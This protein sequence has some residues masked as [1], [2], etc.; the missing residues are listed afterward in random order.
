MMQHWKKYGRN[1]FARY[2]YE[3][4]DSA[5]AEKMMA[6]LA[7]KYASKEF[8]GTELK[9]KTSDAT[10]KVKL[11]DDF[12]YK[13]PV[14]GSVS[15][16]QGMRLVFEDGSRIIFRLSGTGSSG[17]PTFRHSSSRFQ[18]LITYPV[19]SG[20]TI[21]GYF[22]KYSNDPKEYGEDT[23]EG[24]KPLIE[25]ALELSQLTKLTGREKPT[26]IT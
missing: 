18:L 16:H 26:V 9:A 2:D 1:F 23:Q 15:K 8:I 19:S 6:G 14:D 12:E 11:A 3:E 10:F 20:A 5:S 4:V 7:E 24:L 13:D 21:R 25:V 22:E 17:E